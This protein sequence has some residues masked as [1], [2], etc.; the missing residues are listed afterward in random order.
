MWSY[1]SCT[2][3]VNPNGR[4][5]KSDFMW[6]PKP[7][8]IQDR[9]AFCMG[10]WGVE[11]QSEGDYH[12]ELFG[13]HRLPQLRDNGKR[14]L[15]SFGTYDAW[16]GYALAADDISPDIP[17][18]MIHGV[19]HGSDLV[20]PVANETRDMLDGRQRIEENLA[21]WIDEVRSRPAQ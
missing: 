7:W 4:N 17:V 16:T 5:G 1:F 18:V 21:K 11:P 13:W 12:A 19:G 15:F 9:R 8:D 3:V 14:M 10:R 6:P 20:A 2:Q